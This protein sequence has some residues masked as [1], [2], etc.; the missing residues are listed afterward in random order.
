MGSEILRQTDMDEP[1]YIFVS[2]GERVFI[3]LAV[4]DAGAAS[5]AGGIQRGKPV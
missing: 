2:I 1:D 3:Y 5:G 4:R